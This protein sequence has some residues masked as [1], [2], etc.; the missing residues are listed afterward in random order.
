MEDVLDLSARSQAAGGLLRREP[1]P[2]DRRGAPADPGRAG[3]A[4]TLRLPQLCWAT[5]STSEASRP[6]AR[7]SMPATVMKPRK[8][9]VRR[10]ARRAARDCCTTACGG[11]TGPT[12]SR[13]GR[14]TSRTF[15]GR[16]I[17]KFRSSQRR[18]RS[19]SAN[20]RFDQTADRR[21]RRD[22]TEV[23][24]EP[25][26]EVEQ[27]LANGLGERQIAS[28]RTTSGRHLARS[29]CR[30]RLGDA[31]A[32]HPSPPADDSNCWLDSLLGCCLLV[33]PL[34][35]LLSCLL[36]SPTSLI[37]CCIACR[38]AA[39]SAS[40]ERSRHIVH[41]QH[42]GWRSRSKTRTA[43][44]R[45]KHLPPLKLSHRNARLRERAVTMILD[46]AAAELAFLAGAAPYSPCHR[47]SCEGGR[48]WC[49]QTPTNGLT[50][51]DFRGVDHG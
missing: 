23:R 22:R 11:G 3:S 47:N 4:R 48:R 20:C 46:G 24:S 41:R 28:G 40:G 25:T 16:I 8:S 51:T 17:S 1:G 31:W 29:I 19:T 42:I 15:S 35:L 10:F 12:S 44:P 27:E 37:A 21:H 9:L 38:L 45:S 6:R 49:R 34:A 7:R 33:C 2:T 14:A 18:A 30:R 32:W 43:G 13:T 5:I 39:I 50:T 36:D 26:D